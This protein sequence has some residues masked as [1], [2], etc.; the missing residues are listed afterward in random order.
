MPKLKSQVM[1]KKIILREVSHQ[2]VSLSVLWNVPKMQQALPRCTATEMRWRR[3][4]VERGSWVSWAMRRPMAVI[5]ASACSPHTPVVSIAT[6]VKSTL[7]IMSAYFWVLLASAVAAAEPACV[8]LDWTCDCANVSGQVASQARHRPL[9]L[10]LLLLLLFLFL[11]FFIPS[12]SKGSPR[13]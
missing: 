11:F 7:L 9:L 2:F 8:L 10:L 5:R 12:G 13:V 1:L 3:Y 4:I 6:G